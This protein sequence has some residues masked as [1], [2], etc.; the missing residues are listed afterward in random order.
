[1]LVLR[2]SN[3]QG[4]TTR[5]RENGGTLFLLFTTKFSSALQF[6]NHTELVSTFFDENRLSQMKN[7]K[8]KAHLIQF[9][10]FIFYKPPCLQKN[11]HRGLLSIRVFSSD[12]HYLTLNMTGPNGNSEFCFPKISMFPE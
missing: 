1:M 8:K 7:L 3:F 12:G 10:L 5:P 6:K 4:T 9:Q 2:T 11:V